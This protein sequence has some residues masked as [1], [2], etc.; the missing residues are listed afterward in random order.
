MLLRTVNG[1][2]RAYGST[3]T[4]ATTALD[5]DLADPSESRRDAIAH[6]EQAHADADLEEESIRMQRY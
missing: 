1:R 3:R 2:A 6:A 4:S 5:F